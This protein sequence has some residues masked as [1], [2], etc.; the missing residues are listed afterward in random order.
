MRKSANIQHRRHWDYFPSLCPVTESLVDEVKDM[1]IHATCGQ[2]S[3]ML[4]SA[5]YLDLM[6]SVAIVRSINIGAIFCG[7]R[8]GFTQGP[9]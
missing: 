8:Q 2:Y 6:Y 4:M 7:I 1:L 9:P 5:S 3:L